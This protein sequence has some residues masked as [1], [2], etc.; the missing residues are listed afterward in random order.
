MENKAPTYASLLKLRRP[1]DAAEIALPI[2]VVTPI[3]GGSPQTRTID[4][5]DIIRAATIRGHLRFWWRA[6]YAHQYD[7][8]TALIRTKANAGG[9]RQTS[10]AAARQSSYAFTSSTPARL[11]T[12][13]FSFTTP[14]KPGQRSGPMRSGRRVKTKRRVWQPLPAAGPEHGFA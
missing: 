1:P 3:L 4:A 10:T 6:L 11:M 13:T 14:K 5:V 2:E 12:P 7:C 8:P 9:G